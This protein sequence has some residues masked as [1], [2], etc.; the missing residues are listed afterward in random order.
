[1]IEME[2]QVRSPSLG[3]QEPKSFGGDANRRSMHWRHAAENADKTPIGIAPKL[4]G[5]LVNPGDGRATC[6][7]ISIKLPPSLS[8][9]AKSGMAT[10]APARRKGSQIP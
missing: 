8:T 9:R 3:L 7:S 6:A 4:F 1:L 10:C 5:V 2:A